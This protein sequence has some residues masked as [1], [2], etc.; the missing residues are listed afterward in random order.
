MGL[1]LGS[2]IDHEQRLEFHAPGAAFVKQSL[3]PSDDPSRRFGFSTN[4]FLTPDG[5]GGTQYCWLV[6]LDWPNPD[7]EHLELFRKGVV[8]II[9]QDK[10]AIEGQQRNLDLL[11]GKPFDPPQRS[12]PFDHTALLSRR[13]LN[14]MVGA[15]PAPQVQAAE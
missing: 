7:P 14:R 9:A 12:V 3:G 13:I 11:R 10:V 2:P 6:S 4:H 1:P 5:R 8:E 15:A